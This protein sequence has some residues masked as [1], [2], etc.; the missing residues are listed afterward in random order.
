MHP[1]IEII[2]SLFLAFLGILLMRKLNSLK[3]NK[4][5]AKKRSY[6][7]EKYFKL[8]Y[9]KI[10]FRFIVVLFT[11]VVIIAITILIENGIMSVNW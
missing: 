2:F 10:S 8:L 1:Y 11:L 5:G 9:H 3:R 4:T 6:A 7:T